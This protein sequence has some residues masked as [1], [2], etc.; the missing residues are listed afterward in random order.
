MHQTG[1]CSKVLTVERGQK[2]ARLSGWEA[3]WEKRPL[4][5]QAGAMQGR[6]ATYGGGE[7]GLTKN[8]FKFGKSKP[9]IWNY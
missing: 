4:Q 9:R 2:A 1:E 3:W 8:L 6:T 5:A 7:A